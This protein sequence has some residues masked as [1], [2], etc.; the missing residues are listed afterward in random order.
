MAISAGQ[1][2][3]GPTRGFP[4]AGRPAGEARRAPDDGRSRPSDGHSNN[5]ARRPTR[6]HNFGKGVF[7]NQNTPPK[8]NV[9]DATYCDPGAQRAHGDA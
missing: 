6:R 9:P 8:T 1:T 4:A 7:R 3:G 5:S 2:H